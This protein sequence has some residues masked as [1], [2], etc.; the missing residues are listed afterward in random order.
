VSSA[1]PDAAVSAAK[2]G[3]DLQRRT[4]TFPR[5]GNH[6]GGAAPIARSMGEITRA[7]SAGA[8]I[9]FAFIQGSSSHAAK[10]CPASCMLGSR[11]HIHPN[12]RGSRSSVGIGLRIAGPSA[13]FA[14]RA[15]R[16]FGFNVSPASMR[17]VSAESARSLA[18]IQPRAKARSTGETGAVCAV[19]AGTGA[20]RI[21]SATGP[22]TRRTTAFTRCSRVERNGAANI[23]RSF[24]EGQALFA[25]RW[26]E[27][28][29][30]NKNSQE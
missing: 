8:S 6:F 28:Y 21:R 25:R 2:T 17:R 1:L 15:P 13:R 11:A 23:F 29:R 5:S 3:L 14:A 10:A 9:T 24:S 4:E 20:L 26:E 27:I 12:P 30:D 16:S 22:A 19:A 18:C 7:I